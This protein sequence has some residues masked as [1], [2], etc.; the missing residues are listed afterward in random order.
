[1]PYTLRLRVVGT[2]ILLMLLTL[3]AAGQAVRQNGLRALPPARPLERELSGAEAHDYLVEL[4]RGELFKV[5]VEQKGV[6]V[7]L[8]LIDATGDEV[9]HMD[10]PNG[11]KGF[12]VLTFVA[13]AA[14]RFMLQVKSPNEKA[15]RGVYVIEREP[16]RAATDEDRAQAAAER[17]LQSRHDRLDAFVREV[18]EQVSK[19]NTSTTPEDFQATLDF[20][21]QAVELAHGL[22]SVGG[23]AL[24][25]T[26]I[27]MMYEKKGDAR[28]ALEHY[29]KTLTVINTDE[30]SKKRYRF[31][32]A[33][34]LRRMGRLYKNEL[35]DYEEAARSFYRGLELY[36]EDEE[37]EEKG[38]LLRDFG[39]SL[40][41][42]RFYPQAE[43]T[44][45][46][47][48]K[49]F[50]NLK[51]PFQAGASLG[52][53]G[54]VYL[55]EGDKPAKALEC[56]LESEKLLEDSPPDSDF[57]EMR[58]YNMGYIYMLYINLH[59]REKAEVYRNKAKEL[60]SKTRDPY[61]A[62]VNKFFLG[63]ALA[64]QGKNEEALKIYQEAFDV[65]GNS[66]DR[67]DPVTA[68]TQL[69]GKM[70][71]LYLKLGKYEEAKAAFDKG[72]DML[73]DLSDHT[74]LAIFLEKFAD[75]LS[76]GQAYKVAAKYYS[77][78]AAV[79]ISKEHRPPQ[80]NYE[81]I[82]RVEHKWGMAQLEA[83]DQT[84]ALNN[85]HLS[86]LVQ[87]SLYQQTGLA[88]RLSDQ[89]NV[90]ARLNRNRLAIFLGKQSILLK[91]EM[92]RAI[93]SFPVDTQKSFLKGNRETY[94]KLVT[95]LLQ[96]GRLGE[97]VQ[98]I[99]LYQ[100]EEFYDF[101]TDGHASDRPM[102]FTEREGEYFSELRR[103]Q[104]SIWTAKEKF[105][106]SPDFN[107]LDEAL[108][109]MEDDLSKPPD[110]KDTQPAVPDL[111]DMRAVVAS[112]SAETGQKT[113]AVYTVIGDDKFRLIL[114]LPNGEAKSLESPVKANDLNEKILKFYA[115]LQSS[116]YDPRPL[117]RELYDLILK[118]AEA[119]LKRSGVQTLM[120][121]LDGSLRYVPMAALWDGERYLAERYRNVVFTRASREQMTRAVSPSWAGSGFGSSRARTVDLLGDG[122]R[123]NFVALPGVAAELRAI[124][125]ASGRAGGIIEGDV[126]LDD[127]FS[128][129]SFYEAMKRR[130]PL[131]HIS[132]HFAFRP[133][134]DSRS[135]LL[136]GDGTALTLSEMKKQENLFAGVEMLTLSACNTA[137]T[138]PD[139]A[140]KEID[141]FAEL[142]QRLG[143]GAVM[144][145]L[146][147]VSDGSTPWLM[148]QFYAVRQ[149]RGGTTKA[150]ALRSAQ[151]A[152]LNGTAHTEVFP[153]A[154]KGAAPAV[155]V[156]V[157]KSAQKQTPDPTRS[158]TVYVSE[159][160]APLFVRDERRPYAHPY[161]W[162]P[163]VL[164]GNWR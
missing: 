58:L 158:D 65:A 72:Y 77:Q 120:W 54:R 88:D 161:Y 80:V 123:I 17:E 42:Y 110:A 140:G 135:F 121:Q 44:L 40:E 137:A 31:M 56:F 16:P 66:F 107:K 132:S 126:L 38:I 109:R 94:E 99:N 5:K 43:E 35:R 139:A 9:A 11:D 61:V 62:F 55:N 33:G 111:V 10:S 163:F 23:E 50:Q 19:I 116:K 159:N 102:S 119:D 4:R 84:E 25:S 47:A 133:G 27:A 48:L 46:K 155:K 36:K 37:D 76:D 157:T 127:R 73:K 2:T 14:G 124:F 131:V 130:R 71:P 57:Q 86:L 24:F 100:D 1:M 93:K 151:L 106:K 39:N 18:P 69:L 95:L 138:R 7:L 67:W 136:L 97:A 59:D 34:T 78:A 81:Q 96:E 53:L 122:D 29:R 152:L 103:L 98:V 149:G 13:D 26:M 90:F 41:D 3:T 52:D 150:E 144:A 85:L 12:E 60:E 6:D 28:K 32:E 21:T 129:E 75:A 70:I 113:A 128:R 112:L 101:D 79:L 118:P 105:L 64:A 154:P 153:D 162:A 30:D 51:M 92:R 87:M 74:E 156:L 148:Q 164:Y 141:G 115:L 63:N 160:D 142:A 143:A 15:A 134:D 114:V 146:W 82:T 104:S 91:Q 83:G 147:Q 45:L 117:G 8:T 108:K 125:R 145:T 68:Q 22:K 49:V 89:M 20:V